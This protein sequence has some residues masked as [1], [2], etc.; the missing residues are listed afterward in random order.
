MKREGLGGGGG[1]DRRWKWGGVGRETS[2]RVRA[3]GGRLE[4]PGGG[5]KAGRM[6]CK[7]GFCFSEGVEGFACL[8]KPSVTCSREFFFLFL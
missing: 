6:N 3:K 8:Q 4:H 5:R 2:R 7:L 1:Q